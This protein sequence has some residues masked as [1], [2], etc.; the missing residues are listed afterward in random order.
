MTE[1]PNVPEWAIWF[2]CV[3][4]AASLLV[5]FMELVRK[6]IPHVLDWLVERWRKDPTKWPGPPR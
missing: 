1:V 2:L 4:A 3:A 5:G 6:S